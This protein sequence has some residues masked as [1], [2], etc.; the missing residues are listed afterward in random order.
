[1]IYTA[2]DDPELGYFDADQA[3]PCDCGEDCTGLVD[4][5]HQAHLEPAKC[6]VCGGELVDTATLPL[7]RTCEGTARAYA[8]Y[9][10]EGP[11][12]A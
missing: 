7:C 4:D 10:P 2:K 9:F 5:D 11:Y 1:M 8:H 12:H 3:E 6:S